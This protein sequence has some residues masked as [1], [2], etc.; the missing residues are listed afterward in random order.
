M[1]TILIATEKPFAPE[2][3]KKISKVF[4]KVGYQADFL[5]S[6]QSKVDFL[7]A[8]AE[9]EALIVRSDMVDSEVFGR[10]TKPQNCCSCRCW[11]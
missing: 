1:R 4:Q 3:A 6:Y 5:E 11:L 10:G 2:A 7:N 9:S 8:V